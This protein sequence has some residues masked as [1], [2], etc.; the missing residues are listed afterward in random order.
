[1]SEQ[2]LQFFTTAR[3]KTTQRGWIFAAIIWE[4][5]STNAIKFWG[6]YYVAF[7]HVYIHDMEG[8]KPF[9]LWLT[10][11]ESNLNNNFRQFN[12]TKI[13]FEKTLNL[14]NSLILKK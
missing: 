1:M 13:E 8:K 5:N 3:S 7:Y 9:K 11:F 14:Y 10:T 2:N 4:M 6:D 12:E